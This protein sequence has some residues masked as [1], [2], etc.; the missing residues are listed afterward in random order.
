MKK[1]IKL[2]IPES[3]GNSPRQRI[4][5]DFNIAA[6]TNDKDYLLENTAEKI[7]WHIV[8]GE[9]TE[10]MEGFMKQLFDLNDEV[11][12]LII[13][14]IITHG[15]AASAH[16]S[17]IGV[18]RSYDFCHVYRFTGAT[19]TAKIKEITSYIIPRKEK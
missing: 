18:N 6:V 16:G 17:V 5:R 11:D 3:C 15:Y 2:S 7:N 12:E 1:E 8:G 14:D 13:H 9:V 10:G 4:L 19:K